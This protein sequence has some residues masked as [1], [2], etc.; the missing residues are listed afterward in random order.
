MNAG[1]SFARLLEIKSV[2]RLIDHRGIG[3]ISPTAHHGRRNI[4]RAR[5]HGD[6]HEA[7][8]ESQTRMRE[9]NYLA[10]ILTLEAKISRNGN[11]FASAFRIKGGGDSPQETIPGKGKIDICH[12][13]S[14]G[15]L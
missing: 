12:S 6:A 10:R 5:P 4:S 14:I 9:Q 2:E 7:T 13:D 1:M 8:I 3:A 11:H 15:Q